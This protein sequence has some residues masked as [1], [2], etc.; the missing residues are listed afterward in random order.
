MKNDAKFGN[1]NSFTIESTIKGT[2]CHLLCVCH[3]DIWSN[4]ETSFRM[5]STQQQKLSE[6]R[7]QTSIRFTE[8]ISK[9]VLP[10]ICL[11]KRIAVLLESYKK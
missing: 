9:D 6:C 11:C 7:T 5:F 2:A 8:H 3:K 1:I 10:G 4:R